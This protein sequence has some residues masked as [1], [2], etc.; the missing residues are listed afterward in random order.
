MAIRYINALLL[1][2]VLPLVCHNASQLQAQIEVSD[3]SNLTDQ[4][5]TSIQLPPIDSLFA[6][7]KDGPSY[8][9]ADKRV[10]LERKLLAKEKRSFLKFFSLRGSYQYGM[11]GN[12]STYTDVSIAP[13]LTYS[14]QAQN[15]YTVGAGLN[16]PLDELFDLR[17]RVKRQR[18]TIETRVLEREVQFEELQKSI[19]DLYYTAN[20]Q[21]QVLKLRAESLELAKLQYNLAENDFINGS[22]NSSELSIEKERQSTAQELFEKSRTELTKSLVTLEVITNTKMINKH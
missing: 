3:Y 11:F 6:N 17:A 10:E 8:R 7:A 9:L 5:Y 13:Y 20:G 18:L 22:I 15:G 19:I 14:T 21:I 16:V 1:L 12:E 4:D 2:F